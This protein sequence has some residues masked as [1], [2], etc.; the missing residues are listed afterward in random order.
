[1]GPSFRSV[2]ILGPAANR[3]C[4]AEIAISVGRREKTQNSQ[5]GIARPTPFCG[6]C[7]FSRQRCRAPRGAGRN[8]SFIV[9]LT[10]SLARANNRDMPW[11]Q[12]ILVHL[13]SLLIATPVGW[14]CWLPVAHSAEKPHEAKRCCMPKERKAPAKPREAPTPSQSCCCCDPLL[15]SATSE[16]TGKEPAPALPA[17]LLPTVPVS[18]ISSACAAEPISLHD[19]SLRLHILHCVWLC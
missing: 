9:H 7:V 13:C 6:L 11:V 19:P 14:C 1:M 10:K 12:R 8:P 18:A 16:V 2:A 15:V 5:K 4:I 3:T 17:V